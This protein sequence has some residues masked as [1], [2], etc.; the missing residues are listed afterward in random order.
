MGSPSRAS[1]SGSPHPLDDIH[2]GP[3]T[4]ALDSS[5]GSGGGSSGGGGGGTYGEWRGQLPPA[6]CASS[7]QRIALLSHIYPLLPVSVVKARAAVVLGDDSLGHGRYAAAE[8]LYLE[9]L[10]ILRSCPTLVPPFHPLVSEL[11][12]NALVGYAAVTLRVGKHKL[13]VAAIHGALRLWKLLSRHKASY[14]SHLRSW[15]PTVAALGDPLTALLLY[16]RV[17]RGLESAE[18]YGLVM[19]VRVV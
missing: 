19:C 5:F 13:A 18:R 2:L 17:L 10:V 11:A 4:T 12:S 6:A 8:G 7:T 14:H 9:A 1:A 3:Y 15:A 16:R